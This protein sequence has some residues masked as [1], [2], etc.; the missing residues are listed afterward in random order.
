MRLSSLRLDELELPLVEPF[1]TSFG[2][3]RNRRFLVVR[4]TAKDGE[5]GWGECAAAADPLYSSESVATARWMIAERLVPLL[6]RLKDPSP[7]RF[8]REASRFR[9]HSMAKAAVE[10]ALHDLRAKSEGKSLSEALGGRRRRIRV[11]V[12][13]GIQPSVRQLVQR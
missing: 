5:V 10:L 2:V 3:E 8:L 9:G 13:V 1:E 7:E 4:V 12:S 6:F 11:G